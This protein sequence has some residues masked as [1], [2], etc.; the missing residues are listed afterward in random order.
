MK[1]ALCQIMTIKCSLD[2]G[3]WIISASISFPFDVTAGLEFRHLIP[4]KES[5]QKLPP[6]FDPCER[7]PWHPAGDSALSRPR[8]TSPSPGRDGLSGGTN[9]SIVP[10]DFFAFFLLPPL[11]SCQRVKISRHQGTNTVRFSSLVA[12]LSSLIIDWLGWMSIPQ[13]GNLSKWQETK[14]I[15]FYVW[16]HCV[17]PWYLYYVYLCSSGYVIIPRLLWNL[18]A[19]K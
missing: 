15:V 3:H 7:C 19:L 13:P 11:P 6:R 2:C 8:R 10:W 16:S 14:E 12:N 1:S 5:N 17:H 4:V 18:I 9:T